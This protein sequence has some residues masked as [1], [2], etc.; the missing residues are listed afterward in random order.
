MSDLPES[1][2]WSTDADENRRWIESSGTE[3]S[4]AQWIGDDLSGCD[5]RNVV[6]AE[7]TLIQCDFTEALLDNSDLSHTNAGGAL[8]NRTHLSGARFVKAELSGA[9]FE[10]AIAPGARFAKATLN[11]ARFEGANLQGVNFE[12]ANLRGA[13]LSGADLHGTSLWKTVLVAADLSRADLRGAR[14]AD[15]QLDVATRLD[16]VI[17]LAEAEIESIVVAGCRLA[18]TDARAWLVTQ[19]GRTAWSIEDLELWLLAK[20]SSACVSTALDQLGKTNDA[21]RRTAAE[22]GE[23]FDQAGHAAAEYRRILGAPIVTTI[24]TETGAFAGSLR[25][26]YRL[27][28]WLDVA[29]VVN[30]HP[31][32]YAWSVGFHGGPDSLPTDLATI[33]PWRWS[34][35]RL[36]GLAINTEIVDQWSYDLDAILTFASGARF[37]ARF[38]FELLQTWAP[39]P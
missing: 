5:L 22:L 36:R 21:L 39:V 11:E 4:V 17:G 24:A 25:H 38:D 2:R 31:S 33:A 10:G 37:R 16:G 19:A 35:D 18:G 9:S 26:E 15:T 30:E 7:A 23:I 8:F 14:F 28:L 20:M 32:G 3:G 12:Q 13:R 6:L 1:P 29:F 34:A 27:P